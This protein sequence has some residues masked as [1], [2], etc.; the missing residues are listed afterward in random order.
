MHRLA[1]RGLAADPANRPSDMGALAD[2]LSGDPP[3]RRR[4]A[5]LVSAVALVVLAAFWGVLQRA[6]SPERR[7]QQGAAVIDG[8][9]AQATRLALRQRFERAGKGQAWTIAERHLARYAT[10]WRD[11]YRDNCS[12]TYGDRR[13]SSE[14]FDLRMACL[15]GRRV[16]FQTFLAGLPAVPE[17]KLTSMASAPAGLP[18]LADCDASARPGLRALPTDPAQRKRVAAVEEIIDQAI[19]KVIL[20]DHAAAGN[21]AP[22]ATAA[23]RTVGY[24]PVLARA[25]AQAANIEVRRGG[26]QQIDGKA[27]DRAAQMLEEAYVLADNGHDDRMRLGVAREL[28]ITEL[29]RGRQQEA[30]TW[31]KRA[32][33]ILARL[34]NPLDKASD[35]AASIGWLRLERG[36]RSEAAESFN[37]SVELK[38]KI[39]A[40][41]D[42]EHLAPRVGACETR[43]GRLDRNRCYRELLPFARSALGPDHPTVGIIQTNLADGLMNDP[44]TRAEAC[45]LFRSTLSLIERNVEPTHGTR[46]SVMQ[47]LASCLDSATSPTSPVSSSDGRW[48]WA[49]PRP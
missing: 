26:V 11:A 37:R 40:P 16:A 8:D 3:R 25:L 7:C 20:S 45:E 18:D 12:A 36:Q 32:S 34:G 19:A 10:R 38:K 22:S 42:P 9:F 48:R 41:D 14:V 2:A 23:A 21:L 30:E 49:D 31:A 43:E 39:L 29:E 47:S 15:A 44:A 27:R 5:L 1:L 24:E 28:I 17:T 35:L 13:Q 6:A 46:R 33:A 4:R